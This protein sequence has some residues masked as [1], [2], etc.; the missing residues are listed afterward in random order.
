MYK[1]F[2]H[3]KQLEKEYYKM[4][5][6]KKELELSKKKINNGNTYDREFLYC[7]VIGYVNNKKN[8]FFIINKGYNDGVGK[9]MIVIDGI[10]I[11]G[12][13]IET[14]SHYSKVSC[15]DNEQQYISVVFQNNNK[16]ILKGNRNNEENTMSLI[17]KYHQAK[18]SI[19][20]GELVY[21]SGKGL[22]YPP[23]YLVG[24]VAQN[25][26]INCFEY[27][28]IIKNAYNIEEIEYCSVIIHEATHEKN[29][30]EIADSQEEIDENQ[31]TLIESIN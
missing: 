31:H 16:G 11:L 1:L 21:S 8:K 3:Y 12:K 9:N 7:E 27:N 17:H 18:D 25:N 10:T 29:I 6:I 24:R 13:I 5:Y 30:Q 19:E 2:Y 26:K 22:V 20:I 14:Y 15:L 4:I 23:G 28:I